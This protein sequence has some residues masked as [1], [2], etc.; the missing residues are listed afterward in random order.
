[1][2]G[3][4]T[5]VLRMIR[6]AAR[7]AISAKPA[8]TTNASAKPS[9]S[10]VGVAARPG[11]YF[12]RVF[13]RALLAH[14]QLRGSAAGTPDHADRE[15]PSALRLQDEASVARPAQAGGGDGLARRPATG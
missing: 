8:A 5:R 6:K 13:A 7:A 10:A 4:G 1:M 14:A 11:P 12:S 3:C 2:P 9:V 15:A